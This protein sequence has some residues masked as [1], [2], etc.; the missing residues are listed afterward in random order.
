MENTNTFFEMNSDISKIYQ[1]NKQYLKALNMRP[2]TTLGGSNG[3]LENIK[4]N[5][6]ELVFPK[7]RDVY[8]LKLTSG[9]LTG[10]VTI[11]I[12]GES[13]SFVT[14]LS[15][16][17]N[18]LY[19]H[20]LSYTKCYNGTYS[21]N[22][23]FA[24]SLQGDAVFIYMNPEYRTG[25]ISS[26]LL[27]ITI[28]NSG[29]DITP[30]FFNTDE[31]TSTTKVPYI[32]ANDLNDPLTIIGST[33]INDYHYILTCGKYNTFKTGQIWEL[34]YDEVNQYSIVKLLYHDFLNF[35]VNHPIPPTA[36]T[37]RYELPNLQRI[38]FSDFNNPVR[39]VNIKDPNLM[40][41][42][43]DIINA[44]PS[45][46]M[47][48]PTL[49]DVIANGAINPLNNSSTY[50]MAYRLRKNNNSTTN[51]SIPSA[52][53]T[54]VAYSTDDFR[55][56]SLKFASLDGTE[57]TI[58]KSI[59]WR[60]GSVDTS[61]D[62]MECYIIIRELSNDN[63]FKVFKYDEVQINGSDVLET[64]FKNDIDNFEDV[65]LDEF[66]IENSLF[67]HAKTIEQKDN[68]LFYGNIKNGLSE[69]VEQYDTRVFR[70]ENTTNII[71]I[72]EFETDL[73]SKTVTIS[74]SDDFDNIS[75]VAD[76]IPVYNLNITATDD[77]NYNGIVN[78]QINSSI[79]GG[80][81]KN[82][83][84]SFGSVLIKTDETANSPLSSGPTSFQ[85]GSARDNAGSPN[86]YKYGYRKAGLSNSTN[87]VLKNNYT[88]GSSE[89]L[90]T[91]SNVKESM[92]LEFLN[93]QFR[94]Y[95]CNEIYRFAIVFYSKSGSPYFA[96]YIGDI[97]F[98]DYSDSIDP[99]LRPK[100]DAGSFVTTF[101][102]MVVE[103]NDAYL[104][105]PYINF[106]VNIT[107]ELS[108]VIS[109]YQI[110]RVNRTENDKTI[111]SQG[112]ITQVGIH[113]TGILGLP[114]IDQSPLM[115]PAATNTFGNAT[116]SVIAYQSFDSLVN[117]STS[118]F[119]NNDKII[120]TEKYRIY[121]NG[122]VPSLVNPLNS[123]VPNARR[124]GIYKF[125]NHVANFYNP[126]A[127]GNSILKITNAT[128]VGQNNTIALPGGLIYQ[129]RDLDTSLSNPFASNAIG[130]PTVILN[131]DTAYLNM[132]WGV[133]N[134][135]GADVARR[136]TGVSNVNSKLLALHFKPTKLKT[137][138][139]GRTY[140]ARS[141]NKYITCGAFYQSNNTAHVSSI[142]V[143]GGDIFYG[144][145]DN[146]KGLAQGDPLFL[147]AGNGKVKGQIW[148]FPGQST[149]NIDTR[150]GLRPNSDLN[151]DTSITALLFDN[152]D[153]NYTYSLKNNLHEYLPKPINFNITNEFF[154]KIL[155]SEPKING[156]P[157]DSWA[158]IPIDNFYNIDGNYGPITAL[159][160]FRDH[161][162]VIQENAF[163][164]LQVNP[165]A[166]TSTQDGS[167]LELATGVEV[168]KKHNYISVDTGSRHQWS[169][170]KSP[171]AITFTDTKLKKIFL[172]DGNQLLPVSD[173]KGNRGFINKVLNGKLLKSD[174]P[175]NEEGILV[176]YDYVNSEFLYTFHNKI[177]ENEEKDKYTLV[178]SDLTG[179]FTSFYS[180]TPYI[181]I[182]NHTNLYSINNTS[183]LVD[184]K[185]YLHNIG[186]YCKFYDDIYTCSIKIV[187]NGSPYNLKTKVFDNLTF[188]TES[189]N[190]FTNYNDDI[191]NSINESLNIPIL[192]DTFT[193]V[194]CYNE[195]Q[196]TDWLT[197]DK[198]P[199][200]ANLRRSEQGWNIQI[201]RNK[202]NYDN[203]S[204]NVKSIFDPT[205]LTKTTFGERIRDKYL[206][207]DLE[208]DNINNRRFIL[209]SLINSFKI[210]DR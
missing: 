89:Q 202:V 157:D 33:Y 137:Q 73:T 54:P 42:S 150:K 88:G 109:G 81:G 207:I 19:N 133:F 198:T 203:T 45:I 193:R 25:T 63:V 96:K 125:Y 85:D 196:N 173:V 200:N 51:Y 2:V 128:Y 52:L 170:N 162:H 6:L 100:T 174:N 184:T 16:S 134:S 171:G 5:N 115:A 130:S 87:S 206:I 155:W 4:G 190:V 47:S 70:F 60:I 10:T 154:N 127:A 102:S 69:V 79:V 71:H 142:N 62:T 180:F 74:N 32:P 172:Y 166:M 94:G 140:V 80:T 38:Y 144:I 186:N 187:N 39:I 141:N 122:G 185:L 41:V 114:D 210:S 156:E 123:S 131:L 17:I 189:I 107:N 37:G 21:S 67:T 49:S 179:T 201:P 161:L 50:Q 153:Y 64:E 43:V 36:I 35:S 149:M 22:K 160:T 57:N 68:R 197:L 177:G 191:N 105:I 208:Y 12:N 111:S 13:N 136:T 169:V 188:L 61:F 27:N 24:V 121:N 143:F 53:V 83:S 205:V 101:K 9:T 90:Y 168:L 59:K 3:S 194:R 48:I 112:L 145:V 11:V 20:L 163:G 84:F 29:G 182:N 195:Y 7:V 167:S 8:K 209:H 34:Y 110:V 72:K 56:T 40:G 175:V 192:D 99:N 165:V 30:L 116:S 120:I 15:S 148:F 91:L 113:G 92:A 151:A 124:Y 46:K 118:N 31:T 183:S 159:I 65:S 93:G 77:P 138:Y 147:P 139:G 126:A 95:Q 55:S 176:T 104:N 117:K 1:N 178:Y 44:V 158:N 98:P 152:Y 26:T 28:S 75:E 181:Y 23:E 204:I 18:D 97:K 108:K 146:Q 78:K 58:N 164:R 129:N 86:T 132:V 82:I 106:K 14:D 66:L 103:G 76:N 199:G 119:E 135:T